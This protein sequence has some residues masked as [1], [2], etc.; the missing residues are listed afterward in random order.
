MIYIAIHLFLGYCLFAPIMWPRRYGMKNIPRKGPCILVC[1]HR[2]NL[3]FLSVCYIIPRSPAFLVKKEL[4]GIK[5]IAWVF[6]KAGLIDIDRG[7]SDT[8][9]IR[10]AENALKQGKALA[11]FPEGTR[12]KLP[13]ERMG[14]LQGGATLIALRAKVPVIPLFIRGKYGLFSRPKIYAG[15][16]VDLSQ[17]HAQ[18]RVTAEMVKEATA[19]IRSAMYCG[20]GLENDAKAV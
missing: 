18:K 2:S 19:L 16:P 1:N 8:A 4:M 20:A 17:F 15:A 13:N 5:P 3:D 11:I 9:A 12:S 7:A 14:E 6:R 10:K